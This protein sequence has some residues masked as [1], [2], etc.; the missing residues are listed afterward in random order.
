MPQAV[1]NQNEA[2]KRATR[3]GQRQQERLMRIERRRKRNRNLIALVLLV[4]LIIVASVGYWQYQKYQA[5]QTALQD[6]NATATAK[7]LIT[8]TPSAGPAT[9]PPVSGTFTK[10]ADGLQYLDVKQGTGDTVQSGMTVNVQYTGWLQSN[11]KKFDS[12]YDHG[13]SPIPVSIGQGQVIKGWEEGL[14]GMKVGGSRRLIIPPSLAYGAQGYPPT[15]P[16]NA[17][18][19]FDVT[20]VSTGSASGT[21]NS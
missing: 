2:Q 13:G 8:P 21:G 7:A 11:G 5:D 9:P 4:L 19:I 20:V 15:I 12:S 10:T 1:N 3:P 17:T 14:T 6:K 16:A 18:L